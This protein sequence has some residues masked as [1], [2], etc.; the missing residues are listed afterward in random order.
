VFT[1]VD[2]PVTST[3]AVK[4]TDTGALSATDRTTVV[5]ANVAPTATLTAPTTADVGTAF[6][7]SLT[8]ASDRS[9]ADMAA[10]FTYAFDCGRGYGDFG[11][12][13]TAACSS[14]AVG[15]VSVGAKIR[16]RTATSA[17]TGAR[18]T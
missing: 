7:V 15:T 4:A 9:A 17:N 3:I 8:G 1:G 6:D 10:G 18:S 14:N 13:P 5:I 16:D 2:D 11:T 12:S